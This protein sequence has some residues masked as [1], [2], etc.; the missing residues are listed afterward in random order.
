MA[1]WAKRK[2]YNPFD[3]LLLFDSRQFS[4]WWFETGTP[5]FLVETLFKRRV[6][7]LALD[8][9]VGSAELLSTFDVDDMPTEALLLQTGYLTIVRSKPRGGEMFHRLGYPNHGALRFNEAAA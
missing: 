4:A 1:G 2:V 7:S 6:I 5:A 8:D 3:I 9:M